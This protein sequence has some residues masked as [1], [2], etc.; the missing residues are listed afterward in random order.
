MALCKYPPCGEKTTGSRKYHSDECRVKNARA[1]Y[2]N[3]ESK[4]QQA[5]TAAASKKLEEQRREI[6][7]EF[8]GEAAKF[9]EDRAPLRAVP[10]VLRATRLEEMGFDSPIEAVIPFHDLHYG[11]LV[12]PRVNG[13]F[14]FYNIDLARERLTRWRDLVLRFTQREQ[15][16]TTLENAHILALGDDFE[17]HG[18]M[19][20]TQAFS[21]E[22]PIGFQ[23]LGFVDDVSNILLSYLARYK[24]ITVYKVHGN[25]GRISA[26]AKDSY[27]P[28]NIELF[29]WQNIADRVRA[30]TGGEWQEMTPG[31]VRIMQG[32][33]IDFYIASS[34][35]MLVD[36]LGYKHLIVHGHN[37]RGIQATYT[38]AIA[39][40]LAWNSIVGET[41]NYLVKA[42]LHEAQS[43][44]HEIGGE[45]IQGGC[46]VGPSDFSLSMSRPAA[47]LPSQ[48]L[49]FIHP[50]HGKVHSETLHLATVEEMRSMQEWIGR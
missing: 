34:P 1:G 36:I 27:A 32:G 13:G 41:I 35:R 45:V 7:H 37:M 21:M 49:W 8:Y 6:A 15:L 43:A 12:D 24:H 25:H 2:E 29:A 30:A 44:E 18:K 4:A 22:E 10:E 38:G 17:G 39:T 42:H 19:F 31:G 48:P 50:K 40:K 20:G 14:A 11:S 33:A 16:T 9:L 46:F 26:S 47:S 28:D 3:R 5:G 23:Y